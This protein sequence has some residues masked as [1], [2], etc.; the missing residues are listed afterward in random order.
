MGALRRCGL[1]VEVTVD[2]ELLVAIP[3]EP[4]ELLPPIL[5]GASP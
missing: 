2:G 3:V 5:A 4:R 1:L